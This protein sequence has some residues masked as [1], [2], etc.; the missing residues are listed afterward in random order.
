MTPID[1]KAKSKVMFIIIRENIGSVLILSAIL[2]IAA[3]ILGSR[4]RAKRRG[5]GGCGCGCKSCPM[6][7]K[8]HKE[9]GEES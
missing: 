6:A 2:L 7:G 1:R 9:K 8:C 3:L 5:E 4:I